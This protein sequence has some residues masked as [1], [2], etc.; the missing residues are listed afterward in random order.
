MADPPTAAPPDVVFD[1]ITYDSARGRVVVF[2]GL[3]VLAGSGGMQNNLVDTIWEWEA[4]GWTR[5]TPV[6]SP[7]ERFEAHLI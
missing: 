7:G 6:H 3:G 2:G 5:H 4:T 1:G